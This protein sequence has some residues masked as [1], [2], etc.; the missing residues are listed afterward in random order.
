MK[1]NEDTK[2]EP[3][4]DDIMMD[5]VAREMMDAFEKKDKDQLLECF[6]VLVADIMSKMSSDGQE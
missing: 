6:H 1:I 3:S 5:Q 2:P 4:D